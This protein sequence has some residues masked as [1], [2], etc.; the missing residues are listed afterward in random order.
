MSVLH[1][2]DPKG[3]RPA[4]D[5]TAALQLGIYDADTLKTYGQ[6]RRSAFLIDSL[7]GERTTN[8]IVGN[9]GLGKTPLVL[10]MG[11]SVAGNIPWLGRPVRQGR[12][13]SCCGE[14]YYPA[15]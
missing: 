1:P 9:S 8:L 2:F 15:F 7:F 13:L 12:V 14:S 11:L 5:L 10:S 6:A 3:P 4:V